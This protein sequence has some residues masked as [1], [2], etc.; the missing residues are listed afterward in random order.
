MTFL[1]LMQF[2]NYSSNSDV[3][4]LRTFKNSPI[5]DIIKASRIKIS[6]LSI[7]NLIYVFNI[8]R[9]DRLWWNRE[10]NDPDLPY[11]P[12]LDQEPYIRRIR[13]SNN[14]DFSTEVSNVHKLLL[15][16]YWLESKIFS[17]PEFRNLS[18]PIKQPI[19]CIQI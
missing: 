5:F 13:Q 17:Q 19:V 8:C 16:C 11:G 4:H 7:C 6:I 18:T 1:N 9:R 15:R 12:I 2:K 10:T 3:L 14:I